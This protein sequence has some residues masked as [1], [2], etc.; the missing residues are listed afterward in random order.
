[1]L[2]EL[3]GQL[4]Y[5][6]ETFAENAL[7]VGQ[8]GAI[9]DAVHAGVITGGWWDTTDINPP[10][11]P[12]GTS[13]RNVLRHILQTKTTSPIPRLIDELSLRTVDSISVEALCDEA[14][15][16][17]PEEAELIRG[18][19]KNILMKLVGYVVKAS[20]GGADPKLT[21]RILERKLTA[22]K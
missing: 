6:N 13:G 9:I 7:S 8:C 5:R 14:I 22:R 12:P 20:W 10:H 3:L 4:A 18:G 21:R 2:H 17:F 16:K 1:M 15:R 19:K 11:I